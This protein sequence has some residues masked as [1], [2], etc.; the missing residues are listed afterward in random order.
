MKPGYL[1][2]CLSSL[3]SSL[4]VIIFSETSLIKFIPKYFCLFVFDVIVI[5]IFLF[6]FQVFFISVQKYD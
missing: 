1:S 2:I 6:L 5:G 3:I 4:M